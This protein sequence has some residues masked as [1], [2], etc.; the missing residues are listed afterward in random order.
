[1]LVTLGLFTFVI[2]ACLLIFT[3]YLVKGFHV[4][5]FWAAF[6]AA[7]LISVVQLVINIMRGKP[8]VNVTRGSGGGNDSRPPPPSNPPSGSGPVIDV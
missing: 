1:M 2:N 5:S 4:D 6:K 3:G 8:A 7:I